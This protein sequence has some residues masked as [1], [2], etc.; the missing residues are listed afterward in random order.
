[1]TAPTAGWVSISAAAAGVV[2]TSTGPW[3]AAS[4]ASS[5]VVSTTSPRKAVWMTKTVGRSDARTVSAASWGR[6]CG[7]APR[8]APTSR[9]LAVLP[10]DRPL[11]HLQH[12]Q[13]RL[14]R[15]L[16]G[17]DLLHALLALLL[18]L[19]ELALPRD[20]AAVALGQ[21]VLPERGDGLAGDDLVADRRL[22]GHL[23][24]LPRD[25]LL[26]LLRHLAAVL[27]RFVPV[28]NDAEGVDRVAVDEHVELDEVRLA[29]AR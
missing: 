14:L 11:L 20:V 21:D 5:G 3:T 28:D 29:V 4:A 16:H 19:E 17:A 26:Q 9:S 23:V 25:Q 12:R 1:M 8:R 2:T 22:D 13:E 10:S 24:Q 18:L 27:L 7:S 15:N 6:W